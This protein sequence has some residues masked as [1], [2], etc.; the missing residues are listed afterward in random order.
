MSVSR[1]GVSLEEELLKSL[2]E[3]VLTNG[4]ANRSQ[5]IRYLIGKYTV[6]Q[7]WQCDNV[8]AGAITVVYDHSKKD[9]RIKSSDIQFEYQDVILS[10]QYYYLNATNCL[11]I[12]AVKGP[13]HKLTELSDK[14]IGIKGIQHGKLIMSKV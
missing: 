13:S 10:S 8:V 3:Y 12:V 4:F 11:E 14:L 1:F 5:A 9:I 7:K 2:D 6:E